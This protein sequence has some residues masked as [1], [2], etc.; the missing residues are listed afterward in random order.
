MFDLYG[1]S[2]HTEPGKVLFDIPHH[3]DLPKKNLEI[4]LLQTTSGEPEN[5]ST[6]VYMLRNKTTLVPVLTGMLDYNDV[7]A[8]G[9]PLFKPAYASGVSASTRKVF[10]E[11]VKRIRTGDVAN[12]YRMQ[13]FHN[14]FSNAAWKSIIAVDVV[15][16]YGEDEK[17]EVFLHPF[18]PEEL[19]SPSNLAIDVI[20]RIETSRGKFGKE[21][22]DKFAVILAQLLLDVRKARAK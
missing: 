19:T 6:I 13:L 14:S 5:K 10:E 1:G 7:T 18:K 4:V 2:G 15:L 8:R 21:E 12:P 20:K 22:F 11:F 17:H 16:G 3:F 9:L